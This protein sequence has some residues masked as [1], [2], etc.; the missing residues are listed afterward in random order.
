V[1]SLIL[2]FIFMTRGLLLFSVLTLVGITLIS[3]FTV[4]IVMAQRLL[5][6]NLG[7]ASGLMVGFAIGTGGIGVTL[8]G[9]IADS[10]GVT[11]ALK[12]LLPLPVT[13]LALS[14]L[15]RYPPQDQE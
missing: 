10:F 1:T 6:R 8:L 9:L 2:P 3:S 12:S 4:T 7:I 14:L 11:W 13:G 5:P 15:I